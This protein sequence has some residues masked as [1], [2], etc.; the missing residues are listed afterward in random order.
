MT[1]SDQRITTALQQDAPPA[2]DPAFRLQVLERRERQRFRRHAL[3][4]IAAAT[5]TV[6][7][8]VVFAISGKPMYTA[9][10]VVLFAV[11]LLTASAYLPVFG[12]LIRRF[13]L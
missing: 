2:G 13:S 8:M 3:I 1:N 9:G 11:A 10:S 4:S 5:M 7:V 12:R 6:T